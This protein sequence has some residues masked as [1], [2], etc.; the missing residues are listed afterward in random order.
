MTKLPPELN[1]VGLI[2][3]KLGT[4]DISYLCNSPGNLIQLQGSEQFI[5]NVMYFLKYYGF[6]PKCFYRLFFTSSLSFMEFNTE[7]WTMNLGK[8]SSTP[9]GFKPSS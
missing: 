1:E 2:S 8:D 5:P 4:E 7:V 9:A 3:D 6:Y